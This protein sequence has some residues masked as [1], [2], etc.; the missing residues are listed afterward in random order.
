[1]PGNLE[2]KTVQRN[3]EETQALNVSDRTTLLG[4]DQTGPT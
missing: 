3:I 2:K 1:M 4:G